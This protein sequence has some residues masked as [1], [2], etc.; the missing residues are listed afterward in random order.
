MVEREVAIVTRY[1]TMPASPPVP[2]APG[3]FLR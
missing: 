1:G 3:R 2:T